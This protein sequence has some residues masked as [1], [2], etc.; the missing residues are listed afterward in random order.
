MV[1]L[2]PDIGVFEFITLA[3]LR[4]VQ[5]AAGCSPRIGGHHSVAVLA[6]ME[7][8]AGK[9]QAADRPDKAETE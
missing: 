6:Q 7:I 1:L 5:L 2:P 4:A 8:A 3:R 9:V